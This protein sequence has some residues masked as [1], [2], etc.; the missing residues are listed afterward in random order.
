MRQYSCTRERQHTRI[1]RVATRESRI[2]AIRRP[3]DRYIAIITQ[4]TTSRRVF[5][6]FYDTVTVPTIDR[7]D[8]GSDRR[9]FR[10]TFS[11]RRSIGEVDRAPKRRNRRAV[12]LARLTRK[13]RVAAR[14]KLSFIKVP[15]FQ[16]ASRYYYSGRR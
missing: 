9:D 13:L 14:H 6:F 2:P 15:E 12:T 5:F 3:D 8:R 16:A 11:T 1:I 4:L 7:Q 10:F